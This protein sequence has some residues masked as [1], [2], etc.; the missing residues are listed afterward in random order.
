V[1]LPHCKESYAWASGVLRAVT[2]KDLGMSIE[3]R[4]LRM[5]RHTINIEC[6]CINVENCVCV[7]VSRYEQLLF[8][9]V[10]FRGY[11]GGYEVLCVLASF[12]NW[13][14]M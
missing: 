1:G 2:E 3:A 4:E 12:C 11:M 8:F 5:E 6:I 13:Y 9:I 10:L 14:S 7:R